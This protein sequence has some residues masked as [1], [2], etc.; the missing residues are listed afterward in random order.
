MSPEQIKDQSNGIWTCGFCAARIDRRKPVLRAEV[1]IEMKRVRETAQRMAVMDPELSSASRYIS[2]HE[3]DEVF[4]QHLPDL[5]PE[6]IRTKLLVLA[7]NS[8]LRITTGGTNQSPPHFPV[9]PLTRDIRAAFH[10]PANESENEAFIAGQASKAPPISLPHV[11]ADASAK[12][13]ATQIF[14]ALALRYPDS[15]QEVLILYVNVQIGARNPKTG[16]LSSAFIQVQATGQSKS[17]RAGETGEQFALKLWRTTGRINDLEWKLDISLYQG[18]IKSTSTLRRT[19]WILFD[20]FKNGFPGWLEE[21][22]GYESVVRLFMQG[23]EPVG[24]VDVTADSDSY[25]DQLHPDPFDIDL[26][27]DQATLSESLQR[28]QK[29]RLALDLEQFWGGRMF[30]WRDAYFEKDLTPELI[31]CASNELMDRHG[32][33]PREGVASLAAL[34]PE[35]G[36]EIH[37]KVNP[38]AIYFEHAPWSRR[39]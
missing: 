27:V 8:I 30:S 37:F 6:S 17:I 4:W 29:I 26:Q 32:L 2:P 38:R 7:A 14:R 28:C 10:R 11:V 24:Y 18:K 34:I 36:R 5:D 33:C 25:G 22:E 20:S 12:R 1:L 3:W 15:A 21:L 31:S 13:R 16:E 23:W 39:V 35:H 19:P 9:T